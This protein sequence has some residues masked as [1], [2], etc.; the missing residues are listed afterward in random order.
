VEL[1]WMMLANYAEENN[2][3][4]Y[5]QGGGWD[6]ITAHAPLRTPDGQPLPGDPVAIFQGFLV[7]RL[8]FHSTEVER[9]YPFE[10]HVRDADGGEVGSLQG[11]LRP[12]RAPG[13]PPAWTQNVNVTIA[14]TGM[15]LPTFGLYALSVLVNSQHIGDQSFRVI[16]NY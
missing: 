4:L 14:L 8:M 7:V 1:G 16:K 5:V 9:D 10:V 2:G 12:T 3:L 13:L 11:N 15:P 6:T